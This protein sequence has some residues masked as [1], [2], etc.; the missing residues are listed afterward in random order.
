M[1]LDHVNIHTD[2]IA[3][4]TKFL[5]ETAGLVPGDRPNFKFDGAWLYD[6]EGAAVHLVK[7]DKAAKEIGPVDHFAF[8]GDDL[9]GTRARLKQHGYEYVERQQADTDTIQL[10]VKGPLDVTVELQFAGTPGS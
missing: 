8:R 4:M 5:G 3:A 7:A 9:D 2:D 10:F 1:K 6:D